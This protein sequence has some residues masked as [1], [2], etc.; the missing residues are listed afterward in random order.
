MKNLQQAV[1][2]DDNGR[3]FEAD[4]VDCLAPYIHIADGF[5]NWTCGLCGHDHADRW[6]SISGRVVVCLQCKKNNLLVRTDTKEIVEALSGKWK[7]AEMEK[8][9]E[10][11]KGITQYNIDQVREV[12]RNI[13]NAVST[14][15]SSA[16]YKAE[17][18]Q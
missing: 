17:K 3:P 7:S 14:A 18:G 1:Y 16:V 4:K 15:V 10:R 9:N 8:E 5:Y 13:L 2:E 6:W 11:L 12:Q